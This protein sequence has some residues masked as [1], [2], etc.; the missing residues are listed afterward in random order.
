MAIT[1]PVN[2]WRLLGRALRLRCPQCGSKGFFRSYFKLAE[3]C[4]TC[5]LLCNR[6]AGHFV[7]AVGFNTIFSF[8][9]LLIALLLGTW[10]SYPDIA[11]VPMLVA[12][13]AT[14]IVVPIA[15]WPFSHTLWMAFDL[16]WRP[17]EESELDPRYTASLTT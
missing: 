16:A 5:G 7:G 11:V 1:H 4:P 12:C 13:S 10:I 14:A 3:R 9:C 2:R 8:G 6:V 15:F 17:A